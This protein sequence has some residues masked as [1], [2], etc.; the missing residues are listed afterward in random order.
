[1]TALL[2]PADPWAAYARTVVEIVR[3]AEG[4][5][6]TVCAAPPGQRGRW[7][8]PTQEP[9]PILTA[10]DPGEERLELEVNRRLGAELATDLRPR[11]RRLLEAV[12]VGADSGHREEGLAALG[13]SVDQA[14]E[15]GAHYRQDAIFVWAPDAWSLVSCRDERRVDLGWSLSVLRPM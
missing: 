1:V 13:L 11:S 5:F 4:D 2:P 10:W 15:I 3:G 12:G 14:V 8:W 6:V 7:P 9:V